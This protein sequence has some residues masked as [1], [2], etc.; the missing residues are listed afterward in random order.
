MAS[1]AGM[2]APDRWIADAGWDQFCQILQWQATK[3]A[4]VTGVFSAK[5]TTQ[6]CRCGEK[7]DPRM[8]LWE[9]EP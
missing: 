6:C 2:A 7:A 1:A 9:S 4:T 8:E 5:D 3:A